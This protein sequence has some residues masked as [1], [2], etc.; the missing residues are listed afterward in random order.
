MDPR[1]GF[2]T[3]RTHPLDASP[4]GLVSSPGAGRRHRDIQLFFVNGRPIDAPKRVVKLINDAAQK[5]V[6]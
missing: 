1:G 3:K 6:G 5:E 4:G 2:L